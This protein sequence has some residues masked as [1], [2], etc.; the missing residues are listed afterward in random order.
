MAVDVKGGGGNKIKRGISQHDLC[1]RPS[2]CSICP[3]PLLMVCTWVSAPVT[4]QATGFC[5]R[6]EK[7]NNSQQIQLP[8]PQ[9]SGLALY[10]IRR[11]S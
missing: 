5:T 8:L 1:A 7:L 6:G 11:Q 9:I 3:D 10:K 4:Q 2:C